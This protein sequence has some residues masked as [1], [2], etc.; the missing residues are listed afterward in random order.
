MSRGIGSV[1]SV[2][3][4]LMLVFTCLC[5]AVCPAGSCFR[6]ALGDVPSPCPLRLRAGTSF[7]LRLVTRCL[8]ASVGLYHPPRPLL[9]PC[10][11]CLS[12]EPFEISVSFLG[13][14]LMETSRNTRSHVWERDSESV[15]WGNPGR[16]GTLRPPGTGIYA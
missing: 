15:R 9:G 12:K 1:L 7:P 16:V 5:P 11:K 10:L 8:S 4:S 13:K 14:T 2:F 6:W 3:S